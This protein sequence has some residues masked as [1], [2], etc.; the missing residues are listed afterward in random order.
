MMSVVDIIYEQYEQDVMKAHEQNFILWPRQWKAYVDTHNWQTYRLEENEK[1]RIPKQSGVYSLLIQPG[2][3][4][5]P[6]CSYLM[7]VGKTKSLQ[8]RFMDYLNERKSETGRPKIHRF[9]NKY[10]DYVYFCCTTVCIDN[11]KNVEEKL[12]NAYIPPANDQ[13]PVEI[14]RIIGAFK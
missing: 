10:Q 2:I 7:Y 5:H 8:H 13:Y 12:I 11:L 9:L 1:D 6:A 14:R 3:A 4:N